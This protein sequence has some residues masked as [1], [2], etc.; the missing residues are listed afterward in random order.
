MDDLIENPQQNE[1]DGQEATHDLAQARPGESLANHSNLKDKKRKR[2]MTQPQDKQWQKPELIVLVRNQP[3]EAVLAS[4][5]IGTA[6]G[7]GP[8]TVNNNCTTDPICN[9]A[10][11]TQVH[12]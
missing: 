4:C 7:A 6:S 2:Y 1:I 9:A 3:E 12:S 11:N 5:K 10:C 8:G